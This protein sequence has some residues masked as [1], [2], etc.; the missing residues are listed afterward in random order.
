MA[1]IIIALGIRRKCEAS[2]YGLLTLQ[3]DLS[4]SID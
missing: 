2:R 3:T 4:L 1:P